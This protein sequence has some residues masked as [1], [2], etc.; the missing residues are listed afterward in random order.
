MTSGYP[1]LCVTM[2]IEMVVKMIIIVTICGELATVQV[3]FQV[4]ALK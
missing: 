2:V 3:L 4:L 1:W